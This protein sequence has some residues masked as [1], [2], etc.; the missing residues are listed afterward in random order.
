[1]IPTQPVLTRNVSHLRSTA[2]AG[3]ASCLYRGV[4]T[5]AI[6]ALAVLAAPAA[7]AWDTRT[8]L[9]D[10]PPG[11]L[12]PQGGAANARGLWACGDGLVRYDRAGRNVLAA[13][14][15]E[16]RGLLVATADGGVVTTTE[17]LGPFEYGPYFLPCR[18]DAYDAQGRTLWHNTLNPQS[19][20]QIGVDAGG[21]IWVMPAED[22]PADD[23]TKAGARDL[24]LLSPRGETVNR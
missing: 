24:Y 13:G 9:P 6:G 23:L 17:N 15:L 8:T 4:P 21:R 11:V 7:F 1:M 2:K 3:M 16:E 5:L 18:L 14:Y 22:V 19:C 20:G 10:M 12:H